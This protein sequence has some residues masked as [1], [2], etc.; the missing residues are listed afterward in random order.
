M[1]HKILYS[2]IFDGGYPFASMFDKVTTVTLEEELVEK[3][4]MLILW[5]GGD[6]HPSLYGHEV[7]P[8]SHVSWGLSTMDE[9]EWALANKAVSL[10]IPV[11]GICRGAQ[12][13]CALSGGSLI[14]DI[15]GH[16]TSH[17]MKVLLDGEVIGISSLHHQMMYPWDTE[18]KMIAISDPNRSKSYIIRPK[19]SNSDIELKE[20]PCEPE[21]IWFP[22]TKSLAIQGHPEF[23]ETESRYVKYCKELIRGYCNR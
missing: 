23:Y 4:S 13:M 19:N 3:D 10:G 1:H 17:N 22:L 16:T 7:S 12:M 20:I 6:I 14:Q 9:I 18:H 15:S 21:I 2:A 8:K 11:I 5:G